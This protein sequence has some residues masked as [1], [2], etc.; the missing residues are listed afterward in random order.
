MKLHQYSQNVKPDTANRPFSSL[1]ETK[2]EACI[3]ILHDKYRFFPS[4]ADNYFTTPIPLDILSLY[5]IQFSYYL[6]G[7]YFELYMDRRR[8]DSTLMLLHHVVTLALMYFS[9]LGRY[10]ISCHV[11]FVVDISSVA[12]FVQK[13]CCFDYLTLT[14][15]FSYII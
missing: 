7:V 2:R 9:Y 8:K 12:V 15:L 10:V 5:W 6:S 3:M 4:M 14:L 13:F 11:N 1:S